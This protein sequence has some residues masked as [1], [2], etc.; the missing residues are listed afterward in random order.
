MMAEWTGRPVV[1]WTL[2]HVEGGRLECLGGLSADGRFY[3]K[4]LRDGE[5][6]R[7][8]TFDVP[9]TAIR[10]SAEHERG[11]IEAGWRRVLSRAMTREEWLA[12]VLVIIALV[13]VVA[14]IAWLSFS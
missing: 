13:L 3:I 9:A 4:V 2:S 12:G 10:W 11:F 14:L 7:E 6:D 5:A 1:L 8:Q